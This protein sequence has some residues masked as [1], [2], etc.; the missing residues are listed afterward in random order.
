MCL[1]VVRPRSG[2]HFL[3]LI[4][5][6]LI[7]LKGKLLLSLL[8]DHYDTVLNSGALHLNF[9]KVNGEFSLHYQGCEL[10]QF[11]LV[12]PDNCR[13][14]DFIHRYKLLA[15][16]KS[17]VDAPPEQWPLRLQ[18]MVSDMADGRIKLYTIWRSLHST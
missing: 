15:A 10:W 4:G 5:S 8:D 12:D 1:R 7:L 9:D 18:P 11:N 3:T 6:Y 17:I 14:I 16:V 13:Q 2:V